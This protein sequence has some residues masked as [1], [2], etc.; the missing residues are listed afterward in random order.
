[1]VAKPKGSKKL[2]ATVP[3][4]VSVTICGLLV[5][6]TGALPKLSVLGESVNLMLPVPVPVPVRGS[7][8]G[9]PGAMSQIVTT[10]DL[11]PAA[12]GVNLTLSVQEAPAGKMAGQSLPS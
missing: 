4:L 7:L 5:A 2:A 1:V 11:V 8:C 9:L 3:I 10:P 12:V 6:P